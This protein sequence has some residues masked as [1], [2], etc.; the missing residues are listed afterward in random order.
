MP[1]SSALSAEEG[2]G[3]VLLSYH[4][5]V[6][7]FAHDRVCY[8]VRNGIFNFNEVCYASIG[9]N[10]IGHSILQETLDEPLAVL[11]S[12]TQTQ[13]LRNGELL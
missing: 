1:T 8:H 10:D 5:V 12:K 13:K 2:L 6:K 7:K 9:I 11:R 3:W 4:K